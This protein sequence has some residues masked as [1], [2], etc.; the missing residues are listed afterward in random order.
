MLAMVVQ[1]GTNFL[2]GAHSAPYVRAGFGLLT[3]MFT[4]S[5]ASLSHVRCRSGRGTQAVH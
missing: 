3:T 4:T 5:G 1:S 2:K